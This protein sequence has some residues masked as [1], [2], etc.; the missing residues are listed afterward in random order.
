[1][2]VLEK[3]EADFESLLEENPDQVDDL[4]I[5]CFQAVSGDLHRPN[6]RDGPT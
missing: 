6:E 4:F 3:A 2:R 1:M 5:K